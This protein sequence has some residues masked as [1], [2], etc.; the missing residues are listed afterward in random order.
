MRPTVMVRWSYVLAVILA[1]A[2]CEGTA[3]HGSASEHGVRN[4][5]VG[6]PL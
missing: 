1:L 5:R 2:A 6:V 4:V 3:L